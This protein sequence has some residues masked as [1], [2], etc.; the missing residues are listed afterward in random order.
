MRDNGLMRVLKSICERDPRYRPEAYLFV[1]DALEFT[2]KMLQKTAKAGKE[3]HVGGRE[4]T[5]GLRH[6]ALQEFGPMSLRV[7][8]SWGLNR[9]ED[10]GEIVFNLVESGKLRK[11]EED[12]RRDFADGYDFQEAFGAPFMPANAPEDPRR[13]T[14]GG[15]AAGEPGKR[16]PLSDPPDDTD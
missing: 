7:L 8:A 9:T 4:L 10:F 12:S 15:R 1:L 6:F 5:E 11:T 16:K 3:R 13:G 2:T 14:R